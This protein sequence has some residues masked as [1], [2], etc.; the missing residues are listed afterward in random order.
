LE[1][2][3]DKA[4]FWEIMSDIPAAGFGQSKGSQ[5]GLKPGGSIAR[6]KM[7]GQF[8]S[9]EIG[10]GDHSAFAFGFAAAPR[11]GESIPDFILYLEIALIGYISLDMT[12]R[13]PLY[14]FQRKL[15]LKKINWIHLTCE[16]HGKS[17]YLDN[18]QH[19]CAFILNTV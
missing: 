5:A 7:K 12:K 8:L 9:I 6:L 14:L 16:N 18:G 13:F 19:L 1:I 15:F 17:L 4:G 3:T 10:C 2:P 11:S